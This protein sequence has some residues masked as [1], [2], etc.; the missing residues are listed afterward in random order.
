MR[1][2]R[3]AQVAQDGLLELRGV[4]EPARQ[5][6]PRHHIAHNGQGRGCRQ[7]ANGRRRRSQRGRQPQVVAGVEGRQGQV[8]LVPARLTL[9][10]TQGRGVAPDGGHQARVGLEILQAGAIG[11]LDVVDDEGLRT[12][13]GQQEVLGQLHAVEGRV[14][15]LDVVP[16]VGEQDSG[17]GHSR[18]GLRVDG[19]ADGRDGA[20]ANAQSPGRALQALQIRHLGRRHV[21][22]RMG[23]GSLQHVEHGSGV[24]HA[25]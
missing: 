19:G 25:V 12:E 7:A 23:L 6:Q 4:A 17:I 10:Q 11:A 9:Q 13:P 21:I 5:A 2:G 20:V 15:G 8:V 18:D 1:V 14:T 16:Q 3:P 24:A 22:R